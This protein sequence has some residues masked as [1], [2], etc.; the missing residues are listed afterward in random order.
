MP[1]VNIATTATQLITPRNMN[2]IICQNLSDT[3]IYIGTSALVT[4]ASGANS[5]LRIKAAGGVLALNELRNRPHAAPYLELYAVHAG[6][7]TKELRYEI[8]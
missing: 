2:N 6:V 5:G 7:G 8:F 3:D 1:S 4:A